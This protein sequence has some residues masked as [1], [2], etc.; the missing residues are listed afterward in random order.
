MYILICISMQNIFK[1]IFFL[2]IFKNPQSNY[3]IHAINIHVVI[4]AILFLIIKRANT[5]KKYSKVSYR[6]IF[7]YGYY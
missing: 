6:E 5:E 3:K 2:F 7:G 1:I 4:F